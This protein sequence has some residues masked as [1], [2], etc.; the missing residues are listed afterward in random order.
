MRRNGLWLNLL[1]TLIC[2]ISAHAHAHAA[3]GN[4]LDGLERLK[5]YETRRSASTDPDR[6]NGNADARPIA[7]GATVV[8]AD[9]Q[10]PGVITHIWNTVAAKDRGYSRLLR[11]RMYWDGETEPSVDCPL[12]DFFAVGHGIDAPVASAPVQVSSAGR[13]RNCY[14][15]M[16]FRRSARVTVTNEGREPVGALYWYVDWRKEQ[17]LPG[18]TAYFHAQYRQ[19]FPTPPGRNYVVADITG[20]GHYVGT[21]LSVRAHG[22]G[23]WGEG[24]DFF[25]IDGKAEP[26]LQGTGT[27]DYFSDAW[28]VFPH[29]GPFYGTTVWEGNEAVGGHT[30]VYRWHVPDPVTFRKSLRL[31]LEHKGVASNPDGTIRTHFGDR[32]DDFSSVAF[33]YQTEPHR[34]FPQMP[35]GHA[36]LY[37]A[38][39]NTVEGESLLGSATVSAGVLER[40]DL[41]GLSGGAQLFW[42]PEAAGQT[43]TVPVEVK[44]AGTYDLT[45]LLPRSWDYG[46]YQVELDGR[47]VGGPQDLYAAVLTPREVFVPGQ[48]LA[49]GRHLLRFVNK[50][51]NEKSPGHY[52]GLDGVVLT[53]RRAR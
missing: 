45:V 21:V 22:A 26:A 14:W 48:R 36:R 7:P 29:T 37:H 11:L 32:I 53:P 16:P 41:P 35:V 44:E 49:A 52:F 38:P 31:E 24:D 3:D 6:R 19:E 4:P 25:F 9:L 46:T 23:W 15:P 12:G 20:R 33:W 13:A 8:I 51:R 47:A 17:K 28:G 50:G 30:T 42:K 2:A 34:P 40:Q 10:G 39:E 1:L 27:E 43:L 18:D 5:S